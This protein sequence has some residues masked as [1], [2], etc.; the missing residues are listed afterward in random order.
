MQPIIVAKMAGFLRARPDE[1][2]IDQPLYHFQSYATT[3]AY[4]YTF[5]NTAIGSATNGIADTNME[6]AGQLSAGKRF[7]VFGISVVFLPGVAPVTSQST[8]NTVP[9]NAVNDAKG[10]LEGIGS[11]NFKVLN[12]DY[13]TIA[14]LSYLPAGFGT[15]MSASSIINNQQTAADKSM[16]G[17]YAVNG[18]PLPAAGRRLRVPISIPQQVTFSVTITF[19]SL[20]TVGTASRIGIILEGLQIRA[21]Q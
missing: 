7:A 14:P 3:G 20:I 17:G 5:F 2:V 19:P 4:N 6:A 18:V 9:P 13:L 15:F 8:A 21:N 16:F 1:E 12:K 10:V 11:L